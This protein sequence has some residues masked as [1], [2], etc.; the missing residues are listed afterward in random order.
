VNKPVLAIYDDP[1]GHRDLQGFYPADESRQRLVLEQACGAIFMSP[2]TRKRYIDCG[3]AQQERSFSMCDS[4]PE[5]PRFYRESIAPLAYQQRDTNDAKRTLKMVHLGN[6]PEWRPIDSFVVAMQRFLSREDA[7][8]PSLAVTTYGH[9]YQQAIDKIMS[10]H[11][12]SDSFSFNQAVSHEDSHWIAEMSD[13]ML[14]MIGPRHLD[15]QPS[16][17]FVYLGHAKPVLAIGPSGNPIEEIINELGIGVYSIIGDAES[18]YNGI[19]ELTS[20]YDKFR[21]AFFTNRSKLKAFSSRQVAERWSKILDST[22][23]S[24]HQDYSDKRQA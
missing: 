19:A 16:K 23:S 22:V 20:H 1:H 13:I 4:Y 3:L 18:I 7:Q 9:V 24:V 5:D 11:S 2:L 10:I 17:F 21:Q 15:N 8:G 6:L 12:L 14:V